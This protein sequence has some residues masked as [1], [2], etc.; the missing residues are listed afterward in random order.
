MFSIY[1]IAITSLSDDEVQSMFDE[2]KLVLI[3]RY[4]GATQQA[5]VNAGFM[6]CTDLMVLQAYYLY[7]VRSFP[8]PCWNTGLCRLV[9]DKPTGKKLIAK[10]LCIR[11]YTDPRSLF[12]FIGI[13]VRIATRL[14]LHRDGAQFGLP[15]FE[16]EMRR[17]LWWQIVILDKRL[18]EITGSTITALS[19]TGG[20]CR[21]PLNINDTD[22]NVH[23]KDPPTPYPGP[24]EMLFCLTRTE[25]TTAAVTNGVRPLPSLGKTRFQYSPSPT[26]PDLSHNLPLDLENYRNHIETVYLKHC[27]P[28]IP[29]HFFTL[30][31]MRQDLCKLRVIDF[32]TRCVSADTL[33]AGERDALFIE[34]IRVL[35]YDNLIQGADMLRGFIWYTSIYFPF[36]AYMLLTSELR[37]RTTGELCERAWAAICENHDRRGLIR[38]M[39]SPMHLMLGSMF[40][41][42]WDAREAAELQLGRSIAAPK[43]VNMLRQM[44]SKLPRAP[45]PT[46]GGGGDNSVA[47]LIPKDMPEPGQMG[48]EMGGI[49]NQT[50]MFQTFE[51]VNQM[52]GS[53]LPDLDFGQIDWNMMQFGGGFG[54]EV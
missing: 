4:H 3:S 20:D 43:L 25:M 45:P 47:S 46:G 37:H 26:T 24:T 50:M 14:G 38:N 40:V 39:K 42:A 35:E 10:K 34:A 33:E 22:L 54:H 16:V 12:C 21:P 15:P 29:L 23:A 9:F 53:A 51:G 8:I 2:D 41:K 48:Q 31:M 13:A 49:M 28:K 17:R 5:L 44:I 52:F 30:M 18:A 6:R 36:P 32:L 27:D 7:L 11:R 19:S 1:F